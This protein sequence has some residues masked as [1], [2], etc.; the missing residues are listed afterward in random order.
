MEM[1]SGCPYSEARRASLCEPCCESN[2]GVPPC[3][4]SF[5]SNRAVA[6]VVLMPREPVS[7]HWWMENRGRLPKAA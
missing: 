7:L 4:A 5:V 1:D 6:R 3:V 2:S